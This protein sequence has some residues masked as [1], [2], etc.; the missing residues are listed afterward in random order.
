[1]RIA[2]WNV[3]SLKVRLPR[4]EEWLAYA[5]PDVLC[6]QETKVADAA[7]PAMAFQALGYDS[8]SNGEGRWNGVAILS[9]VGIE[10]VASGFDP[11][12]A[13][14]PSGPDDPTDPPESRL[15]S[16]TCGGV[17]V[18]SVYVPNG[19]SVDSD[20]YQFK[21]RWLGQLADHVARTCDPDGA[22]AICGDFNIAPEDRDLYDP[23]RFVGAT[24]VSGPERDALRRLEDWGLVDAFRL[25]YD[26]ERLYS[27]W[28]YRAG[29]FHEGRGMRIDLVLVTKPLAASVSY[30]LIDR[31]ARKGK[32]PSDHAPVFVELSVG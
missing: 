3:N 11:G 24:H 5:Q 19:R 14:G 13:A 28:D 16:A 30:A 23:A 27:W 18:M 20:H 29:D 1:M 22:V 26:Q 21:L 6:L 15:V 31:N 7:F 4:V 10:D 12:A 25:V 17:R 32:L 2:T 9:R 8:V